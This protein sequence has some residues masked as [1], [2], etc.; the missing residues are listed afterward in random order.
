[1]QL[2]AN[3]PIGKNIAKPV[4]LA[5]VDPKRAAVYAP[6]AAVINEEKVAAGEAP[7]ADLLPPE[8]PPL[9]WAPNAED[10]KNFLRTVLGSTQYEKVYPMF[11]GMVQA[12]FKDRTAEQ[13]EHLYQ[14]LREQQ[15]M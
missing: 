13:C 15:E 2:G 9:P 14:V 3:P 10:K 5:A 1:M 6:L 12:Y 4:P 7:V 11:G 8:P